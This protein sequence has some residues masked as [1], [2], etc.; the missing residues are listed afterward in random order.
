VFSSPVPDRSKFHQNAAAPFSGQRVIPERGKT[1][2]PPSTF[3]NYKSK[4]NLTSTVMMN[5]EE[6]LKVEA[7]LH[8]S[9]A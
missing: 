7:N 2:A 1:V 3:D 9:L 4:P 5:L 6:R 8:K